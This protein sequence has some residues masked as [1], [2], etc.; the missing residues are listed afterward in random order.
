VAHDDWQRR[1]EDA[2][3][4]VLRPLASPLPLAFFA[5]GVGSLMTSGLQLGLIPQQEGRELA[6][7]FGAFVFP[8]MLL[9]AV[10]AFLGRETLGATAL[11]LISFSWLASALVEFVAAPDPASS[12]LGVLDL[13]LAVVLLCLGVIGLLGKPLLSVVILLAF[14]RYGLNG[15]YE[16]TASGGVQVASGAIGCVIF[17][18]S[19]HGGLALGLEDAQHRTVLPFGRRGE[20]RRALEGDLGEQ[21]GPMETEAGVRKQL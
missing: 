12:A 10:L 21:V 2:T 18:F 6:L 19:L 17:L 14:F 16:L 9:S 3:R 7:I 8:P 1:V 11:G 15:L 20:A 4:I 5:F 13:A